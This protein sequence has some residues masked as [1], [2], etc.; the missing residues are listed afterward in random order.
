[1]VAAGFEVIALVDPGTGDRLAQFHAVA[2][3]DEGDIVDDENTRLA[4]RFEILD[5]AFGAHHP[6]GAPV[7]SPSAAERA[8]PRTAARELD[9]GARIE[10]AK[11]IF[12][13]VAQQ[14]AGGEEIVQRVDKTRCRA[15]PA[16]GY[17]AGHRGQIAP[18]AD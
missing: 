18:R 7:K 10:D 15:F 14:V 9:R 5:N 16:H 8:I 12:A 3:L 2:F 11:E 4:D 1:H 13:A 17:R 6:V